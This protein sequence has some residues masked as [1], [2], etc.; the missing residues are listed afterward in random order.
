MAKLTN[1]NNVAF[2]TSVFNVNDAPK[3]HLPEYAF[4]GRSN[5][6][7]SSLINAVTNIGNLAKISS[8]PG[9]TVSLNYFLVSEKLYL[10]DLPGYGYAK[11]SKKIQ[12]SI[13]RLV[14][15]YF[16][17]PRINLLFLLLDSRHAVKEIDMELLSDLNDLGHDVCLVL[18]KSDKK[19]ESNVDWE[20]KYSELCKIFRNISGIIY[21]S[22]KSKDGIKDLRNFIIS[23]YNNIKR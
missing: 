23:H 18:T 22:S 12:S 8:K 7:K 21:T 3:L 20:E 17:G 5:V 2:L 1:L 4:I 6:G 13:S 19:R 14:G 15:N 11:I 9:K 16:S 10:V